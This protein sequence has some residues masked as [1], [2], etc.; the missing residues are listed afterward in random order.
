MAGL[1]KVL[2]FAIPTSAASTRLWYVSRGIIDIIS[3]VEEIPQ[4]NLSFS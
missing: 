2:Q 4:P 1:T 3:C